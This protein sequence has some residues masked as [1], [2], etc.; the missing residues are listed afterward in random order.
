MN[1]MASSKRPQ[2]RRQAWRAFVVTATVL[3]VTA[4]I[5][6]Y[7]RE[8]RDGNGQPHPTGAVTQ[9][10]TPAGAR[11]AESP[12]QVKSVTK[13]PPPFPPVRQTHP[14]AAQHFRSFSPVA[15][16]PIKNPA[17]VYKGT[18]NMM[19]LSGD[20][21]R[22]VETMAPLLKAIIYGKADAVESI[23]AQKRIPVDTIV[24]L[25]GPGQGGS[26]TLLD[27]AMHA[28]QRGVIKMLLALGAS[29]EP[30][31]SLPPGNSPGPLVS[32]AGLGEDDVVQML[33][34]QGA[35]INQKSW[36]GATALA[37]AIGAE[38]YSTVKLLVEHGANIDAAVN[39]KYADGLTMKQ[40][41]NNRSTENP[42]GL[43]IRNYLVAHGA[44]LPPLPSG[45]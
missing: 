32:A 21:A 24:Q 29:T 45:N 20:S 6:L 38:N 43:A 5:V 17:Q 37:A 42:V 31:N 23:L 11:A 12:L 34:N 15:Y 18:L 28:G 4:V 26:E 1:T 9:L 7:V 30:N 41:I 3:I 16:G 2:P 19:R 14:V 27:I 39:L 8:W 40:I 13:S 44:Q 36:D 22:D 25:A 35:N 33:L 10:R